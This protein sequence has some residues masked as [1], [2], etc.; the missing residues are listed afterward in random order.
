MTAANRVGWDRVYGARSA[1][2]LASK[3]AQAKAQG[4]QARLRAPMLCNRCHGRM[5][6]GDHALFCPT[7]LCV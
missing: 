6:A 3:L 2:D 7:C 1:L 4:I 5:P